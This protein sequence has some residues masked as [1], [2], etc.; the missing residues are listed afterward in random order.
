MI[1][2]EQLEKLLD[3]NTEIAFKV[4]GRE[5]FCFCWMGKMQDEK[6]GED[7]YWFGLTADGKN[8]FDYPGFD[9]FSSAK[10]FDEKSLLEVWDDVTILE[11]NSCD[12][13]EMLEIYLS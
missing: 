7:V 1:T 5:K 3:F 11:I 9:E 4:N 10:V 12:P 13:M 2:F 8:A 6:I